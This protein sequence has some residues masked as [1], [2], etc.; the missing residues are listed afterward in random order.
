MGGDPFPQGTPC[1]A[2]RHPWSNQ[3]PREG[4]L[5]TWAQTVQLSAQISHCFGRVAVVPT[6]VPWLPSG[7]WPGCSLYPSQA[8]LSPGHAPRFGDLFLSCF[9]ETGFSL[10]S[11]ECPGLIP[12]THRNFP[13]SVFQGQGLV[14]CA[15]CFLYLL[16]FLFCFSVC[17]FIMSVSCL[18][19][20]CRDLF[21]STV[22][23]RNQTRG[24]RL[25]SNC[26]YWQCHISLD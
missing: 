18:R 10:Y 5:G 9:S 6:W 15:T 20:P 26:L 3:R 12:Q 25:C 1:P 23:P 22:C 21:S 16:C 2:I 13:A 19:T 17:W 7:R 11:P 14:L 4:E 8:R 24:V